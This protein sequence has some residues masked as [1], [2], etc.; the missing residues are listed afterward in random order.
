M[1]VTL[2]SVRAEY[3]RTWIIDEG[4]GGGWY[5]VRRVDL[6]DHYRQRGLSTVRCGRDLEEL[7]RNLAQETRLEEFAWTPPPLQQVG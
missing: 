3:G 2:R 1:P 7:K 6:S 4:A 5:A